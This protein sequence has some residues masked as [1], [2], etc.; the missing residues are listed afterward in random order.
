MF[1]K[2]EKI[3]FKLNCVTVVEELSDQLDLVIDFN[4]TLTSYVMFGC[5]FEIKFDVLDADVCFVSLLH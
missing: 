5:E 4:K 1:F 3:N 2:T